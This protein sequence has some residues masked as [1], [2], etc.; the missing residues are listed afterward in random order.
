VDTQKTAYSHFEKGVKYVFAERK[1]E[2]HGKFAGKGWPDGRCA[3]YHRV[4]PGYTFFIE[5]RA[6]VLEGEPP[7]IIVNPHILAK[8]LLENFD[9][10]I[11]A[12]RNPQS[13]NQKQLRESFLYRFDREIQDKIRDRID[14]E[15]KRRSSH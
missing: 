4:H 2:G 1:W 8:G 6:K 3:L 12:I 9:D 7:D 11:S 13:P 5:N 10:Y 15:I 14:K